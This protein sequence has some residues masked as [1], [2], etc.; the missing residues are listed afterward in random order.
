MPHR[1]AKICVQR[2]VRLIHISTDCVFSGSKGMYT[3][4]DNPDAEDVY[5]KSKGLGELLD[6]P[7]VLTLRTSIVGHELNGNKSLLDWFLC[8]EKPVKGFSKAIFSGVTT[9]ELARLIKNILLT[10]PYLAGLYHV[11]SSPI[12]KYSLLTLVAKIYNK[13]IAITED[14][15]LVIDR[16]LSSEKLK[17]A[18]RYSS[19]SWEKMLIDLYRFYSAI[20]REEAY[21]YQ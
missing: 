18:I 2:G 13:K 7:G 20:K 8:Q 1:L 17:K 6:Y 15:S 10:E 16:S 9:L 14:E 3:E 11:S 4:R 12:D 5:G 21:V 19:P